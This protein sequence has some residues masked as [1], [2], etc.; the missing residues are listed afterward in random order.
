MQ[1]TP[2]YHKKEVNGMPRMMRKGASRMSA[3]LQKYMRQRCSQ[4]CSRFRK[5]FQENEILRLPNGS[6]FQRDSDN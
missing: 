1:E 4:D 6:V 5:D 2:D 3:V